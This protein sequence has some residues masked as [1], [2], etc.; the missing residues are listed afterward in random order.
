[1]LRDSRNSLSSNKGRKFPLNNSGFRHDPRHHLFC[2]RVD[3]DSLGSPVY[4]FNS[5][6]LIH[7]LLFLTPFYFVNPD[8]S[9]HPHGN[10]SP[11]S[12]FQRDYKPDSGFTF[13]PYPVVLFTRSGPLS[14]PFPGFGYGQTTRTLSRCLVTLPRVLRPPSAVLPSTPSSVLR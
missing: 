13:L 9:F 14:I 4:S 5:L 10:V 12:P 1:M 11:L 8:L 3:G 2:F 7:L 6:C